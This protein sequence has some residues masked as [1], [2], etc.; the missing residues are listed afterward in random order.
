MST[1]SLVRLVPL[2]NLVQPAIGGT[3]ELL[4]WR[5][6]QAQPAQWAQP[7]IGGILVHLGWRQIQVQL[8]QQ[9]LLQR[10]AAQ[11][12]LQATSVLL[13]QFLVRRVSLGMLGP[14]QRF[15]VRQVPL[16][17][18]GPLQQL[19]VQPAQLGVSA[20]LQR[21]L[22][23]PVPL[24]VWVPCQQFLVLLVC[25]ATL[26][27]V[28]LDIQGLM[29]QM[30]SLV[31]LV[32]LEKPVQL[33]RPVQ[34]VL[35]VWLQI[36]APEVQQVQQALRVLPVPYLDPQETRAHKE[37]QDLL[38]QVFRETSAPLVRLGYHIQDLKA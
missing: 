35:L 5:Q 23:Q 27:S 36:R 26:K 30:E 8:A 17:V 31:H 10:F 18:Q 34:L 7:E 19:Q 6:I 25:K 4:V 1:E 12:D 33:V 22:A 2:A 14:L 29:A 28:L 24:A 15:P 13:R 16:A 11:L 21:F 32:L 9:V 3:L 20:H 38:V 37:T